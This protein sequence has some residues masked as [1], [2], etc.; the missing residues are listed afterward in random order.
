MISAI[1]SPFFLRE[2]ASKGSDCQVLPKLDAKPWEICQ[3]PTHLPEHVRV[4]PPFMC[5][6][7]SEE[8]ILVHVQPCHPQNGY[9][10]VANAFVFNLLFSSQ[11]IK[12]W[13]IVLKLV[14]PPICLLVFKYNLSLKVCYLLKK[15][16]EVSKRH[17]T[18]SDQQVRK[19][20]RLLKSLNI[21]LTQ[22]F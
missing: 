15:F 13:P 1:T 12:C 6:T 10:K 11:I 8:Q 5:S 4:M 20:I 2:C 14:S 3:T 19:K 16:V 18:F 9:I 22:K 7:V 17:K 21:G